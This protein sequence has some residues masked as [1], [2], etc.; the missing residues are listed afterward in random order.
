MCKVFVNPPDAFFAYC[1]PSASF[2]SGIETCFCPVITLTEMLQ[3]TDFHAICVCFC[4]VCGFYD[5][6][7]YRKSTLTKAYLCMPT[8]HEHLSRCRYYQSSTVTVLGF[9]AGSLTDEMA[10]DR[11]SARTLWC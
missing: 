10:S 5:S 9:V 2:R 11:W 3:I 4:F 1:T 8:A 6:P 7:G